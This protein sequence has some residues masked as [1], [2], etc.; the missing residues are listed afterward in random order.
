MSDYQYA[1]VEP[2]YLARNK[3]RFRVADLFFETNFTPIEE[4]EEGRRNIPVFT[5][6]PYDFTDDRGNFYPSAKLLFMEHNDSVGYH[7]AMN[8]LGSWE[9]YLQLKE[10][11]KVGPHIEAWEN[12]LKALKEAEALSHIERI[13]AH[14]GSQAE[15]SAAKYIVSHEYEKKSV[16][17]RTKGKRPSEKHSDETLEEMERVGLS[18]AK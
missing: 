3:K 17:A 9:H 14:G 18:V 1:K 2:K 16:K 7:F 6:K 5:L 11:K 12:E 13:S 8:V 10:S 15:L 4:Q